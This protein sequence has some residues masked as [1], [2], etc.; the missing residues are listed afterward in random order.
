MS[1]MI[2]NENHYIEIR[3]DSLVIVCSEFSKKEYVLSEEEMNCLRLGM[4]P[5]VRVNGKKSFVA[6]TGVCSGQKSS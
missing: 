1:I 4:N 2:G 5:S 3:G 6:I